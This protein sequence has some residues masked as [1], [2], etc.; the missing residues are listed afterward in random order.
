MKDTELINLYWNRSESAISETD[1]KY[2]SYCRKISYNILSN[3]EDSKECVNDTFFNAWNSIPDDKPDIFSAYLGK[4][5]RNLSINR[6]NKKR[7]KKRG[8]GEAEIVL[9]ELENMIPSKSSIESEI[10]SKLIT[11]KL[12]QFLWTLKKEDRIIFVRRYWYV[13]S[14][15]D[16]AKK[17]GASESKVKSILFRTRK[18]LKTY[19]EQEEIYL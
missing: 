19:L 8:S 4:I 3:I 1:K 7:A 11:K 17:M 13:D 6:Y 9:N 16:I 14:I 12:N 15:K 2:G 18:K 5:T 10:E